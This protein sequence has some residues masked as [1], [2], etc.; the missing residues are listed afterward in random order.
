MVD[1]IKNLVGITCE[2]YKEQFKAIL[3]TNVVGHIILTR[4]TTKKYRELKRLECS[5]NYHST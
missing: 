5:I 3:T 1:E 2:G 4:S